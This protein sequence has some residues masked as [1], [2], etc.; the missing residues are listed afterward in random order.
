MTNPINLNT[1]LPW[2]LL[3]VV[4]ILARLNLDLKASHVQHKNKSSK[5]VPTKIG[6]S[7]KKVKNCS[8][9]TAL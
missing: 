4:I 8:I 6:W 5:K 1:D 7:P 9:S 3:P 2:A